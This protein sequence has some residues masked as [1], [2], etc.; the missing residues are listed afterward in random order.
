MQIRNDQLQ[1]WND[2]GYFIVPEVINDTQIENIK[3]FKEATTQAL[4]IGDERHFSE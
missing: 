3:K 4:D 2:D 1:K